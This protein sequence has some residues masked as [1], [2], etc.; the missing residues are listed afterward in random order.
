[1]FEVSGLSTSLPTFVIVCLIIAISVGVKWFLTGHLI[2][3]SPVTNVARLV[4]LV[5]I[6]RKAYKATRIP[7]LVKCVFK[8]FASHIIKPKLKNYKHII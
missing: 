2:Y 7:S 1:M 6:S 4:I 3:I 5:T 8:T